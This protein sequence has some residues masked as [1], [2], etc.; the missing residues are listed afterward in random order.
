M[1]IE[2]VDVHAEITASN[3]RTTWK[4]FLI[5]NKF[6]TK[7]VDLRIHSYDQRHIDLYIFN[8]L[9]QATIQ[10]PRKNASTN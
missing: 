1:I 8:A 4:G 9:M 10:F 5:V 3:M 7:L 2:F 6:F